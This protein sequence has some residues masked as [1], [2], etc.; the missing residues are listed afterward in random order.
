[1][2]VSS[3]NHHLDAHSMAYIIMF[4]EGLGNLFPWNA[5]ITAS[6][7]F[8][9]RFCGTAFETNFENYFSICFMAAQTAGLI[10]AVKY[11][12]LLSLRT[13]IIYPLFWYSTVFALTT[14]FVVYKSI[15]AELLFYITILSTVICGICGAI[16]SSGLF[17]LAAVMPPVYTGAVMNGQ[18]MAGLTVS[19]A[20]MFTIIATA[21]EDTCTDDNAV[22]DSCDYSLDYSALAYFMIATFALLTCVVVFEILCKLP[23]THFHLARSGNKMTNDTLTPLLTESEKEALEPDTIT[24]EQYEEIERQEREER[25]LR[26]SRGASAGGVEYEKLLSNGMSDALDGE[27]ED[28]EIIAS[29]VMEHVSTEELLRVFD[30]IRIPALSVWFVFTVTIGLFPSLIVLLESEHKCEN[31]HDRF[32]NDLWTPFFF[33]MFNLFDFIGRYSA[34]KITFSWMNAKNI[35]IPCLARIVF[36]PL[37]LLCRVS[38]SR[39]PLVFKSDAFPIVIMAI[40][41]LTNG[42]LSSLCMM[43][44]P[45]LCDVKDTMLAGNIMILSLTLGLCSGAAVSFAFVWIGT[46]SV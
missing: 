7:Y 14:L 11:G 42:Y 2:S 6:A 39:L 35:W 25:D 32:Y 31:Y 43:L 45:T 5:F 34:S 29:E 20:S 19:L 38:E 33:L 17:G 22:E 30:Q 46:G 16:L 9:T 4:W 3:L 40:F 12:R 18:G 21:P 23:F 28:E 1:M 27:D 24:I 41:S 26:R 8:A 37:F 44:G 15:D 13:R 10:I 36:V